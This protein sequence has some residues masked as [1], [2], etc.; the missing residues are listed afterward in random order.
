MTSA[1]FSGFLTPSLPLVSTKY[2]QPPLLSSEICQSPPSPSLLTPLVNGPQ[3][4]QPF[5]LLTRCHASCIVQGPYRQFTAGCPEDHLS[6]MMHLMCN[7]R[8]QCWLARCRKPLTKK[9]RPSE[10]TYKPN[11]A[12]HVGYY[13]QTDSYLLIIDMG[14]GRRHGVNQVRRRRREIDRAGITTPITLGQS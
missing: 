8:S 4:N 7:P 14:L 6:G 3:R 11:L 5:Y 13:G 12:E 1:K 9:I 10:Q 2:T